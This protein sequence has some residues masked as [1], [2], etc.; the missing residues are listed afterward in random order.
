MNNR[1]LELKKRA[2]Q[3]CKF[4]DK[5]KTVGYIKKECKSEMNELLRQADMLLEQTF[6]FQDKWDMEPCSTPYQIS[7]DNWL[8]TPN[9]DEE[10]VFMLNRHDFMPKLLYAWFLTEDQKYITKLKWYLFDWIEKNPITLKGTDATRTIDTGIRCMNW[11]Q[12]LLFLIGYDFLSMEE[13]E[14]ILGCL[15]EQFDNMRARYIGKYSLSNW[16]V[17]QT[18]A[19]CVGYIW[20]REYLPEQLE[21]WAW[22][23]L[24]NQ[25]ELQILEDGAHWE[26]SA[27][28]HVEVLNTCAKVMIHLKYAD[29]LS[30]PISEMARN[31]FQPVE[32][33]DDLKELKAAPG[34]GFYPGQQGWLS[35]AV[36]VLSR[37]V[38][39]TSDPEGN[40]LAQC[41]SDVTQVSDV[42]A[43]AAVLLSG[44]N[45]YR[46]AAGSYLDMDSAWQTG[47]WGIN[48]FENLEPMKPVQYT[49]NCTQGGNIFFRSSWDRD[50]NFT[51][52]KN[53]TLGSGHGHTDQTHMSIFYKGLPF[54]VDSGRYTYREDEPLRMKLKNPM[55]HNV[56][57]IDGESGGNAD[58]SWTNSSCGEVFKNYYKE[59]DEFH[60]AE[61]PFYGTLSDY[62]NYLIIRKLFVVDAGIWVSVQDVLCEGEHEWK[63]YFHLDNEVKFE[64][65]EGGQILKNQDINLT[66][67]GL[68]EYTLERGIISKKYNELLDSDVLIST[69]K[70]KDRHTS[71][72]VFAD[73]SFEIKKA[74]VYQFGKEQPVSEEFVTAWDV[75]FNGKRRYTILIWNR[76]TY[77]GGK[78]YLCHDVPIYGKAVAIKWEKESY[79][80]I[81]LKT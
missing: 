5:D 9:G 69:T 31:A 49:W 73:P 58:T 64:E 18:T 40:Q 30:L 53:S 78:M 48:Q 17:L 41:D 44:G 35:D 4:Y 62:T 59:Y 1:Y 34:E 54:L 21:L 43:R 75:L 2:E 28:Y 79:R 6:I 39:Y 72:V 27:M 68:H 12:M 80:R 50:G 26:Q 36:R 77:R 71:S 37:H 15:C 47:I 16:G 23:E 74:T 66:I 46:F 13:T 63:E 61:L 45:I 11:C 20:Y 60:Y 76:E 24:A 42:M 25:L 57:V 33:W 3:Y 67:H 55:A 29:A 56:G 70:M 65:H 22:D 7:L 52:L 19:M 8:D 38:L 10:W 51:W 32:S 81:R 14:I